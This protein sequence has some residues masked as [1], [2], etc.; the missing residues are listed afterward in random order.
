MPRVLLVHS[1]SD[2]THLFEMYLLYISV[3]IRA[4]VIGFGLVFIS[5]GFTV[6]GRHV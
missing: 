3:I 4:S 2:A 5:L 6:R 1:D